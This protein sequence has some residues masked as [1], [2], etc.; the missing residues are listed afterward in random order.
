MFQG[1]RSFFGR[2]ITV[3]QARNRLLFVWL[4]GSFLLMVLAVGPSFSGKYG[5]KFQ[6]HLVGLLWLTPWVMPMLQIML[7]VTMVF[8][9]ESHITDPIQNVPVYR[10]A[11]GASVVYF[12][13]LIAVPLSDLVFD[14]TIQDVFRLS[15]FLFLPLQTVVTL[16]VGKIFLAGA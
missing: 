6:D 1:L 13:S 7:A 4:V 15:T 5:D 9:K 12:L 10:Y 11:L 14:L 3:K 2:P 16:L 8:P